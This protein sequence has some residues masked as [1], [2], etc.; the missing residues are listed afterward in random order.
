M[1]SD[2]GG[3][4]EEFNT[5][6][7]FVRR[8]AA[9]VIVAQLA[10]VGSGGRDA[11]CSPFRV[12]PAGFAFLPRACRPIRHQNTVVVAVEH[13]DNRRSRRHRRVSSLPCTQVSLFFA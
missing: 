11:A 7:T 12:S 10:R 8:P 3:A 4:D 1:G 5:R 9:I 6:T 13:K 2:G